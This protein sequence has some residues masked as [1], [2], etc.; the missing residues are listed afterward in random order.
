MRYT[1][2]KTTREGG[3]VFICAAKSGSESY[4]EAKRELKGIF[5]G[6]GTRIANLR[7]RGC[8]FVRFYYKKKPLF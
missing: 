3:F 2:T 8:L 5:C 4:R 1:Y 7:Y 6:A